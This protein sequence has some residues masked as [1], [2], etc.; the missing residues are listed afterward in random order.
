M[1]REAPGRRDSEVPS[2]ARRPFRIGLSSPQDPAP[3]YLL[4]LR[5]ACTKHVIGLISAAVL[6]AFLVVPAW[7]H[8]FVPIS[9]CT[10]VCAHQVITTE[11]GRDQSVHAADLDGD[12]DVLS[13]FQGTVAWHE[14]QI[15]SRPS[16]L[17][18][19]GPLLPVGTCRTDLEQG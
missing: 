11:A 5:D 1:R 12:Q 14:N 9:L 19:A 10:P 4:Y 15:G 3:L 2:A 16:I 8:Q 18:L 13:S 6:L 7:A 17:D